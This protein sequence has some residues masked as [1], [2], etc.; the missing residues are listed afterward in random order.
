VP[1]AAAIAEL[2]PTLAPRARATVRLAIRAFELSPFPR[3]FSSLGPGRATRHIER[4]E[5]SR[6]GLRRDLALLLKT[7]TSMAFC[8]DER[9][10]AAVGAKP[11]CERSGEGERERAG[12][13]TAAAPLEPGALVAPEG[14]EECDVVVVGSGAGGAAAARVLAEAGLSVVVLEEG[15]YLSAREFSPDPWAALRTLYRDGG[16]TFCEGRPAIPVPLGRCVGGTTVINSGTCRRPNA[17]VFASWREDFG[18]DWATELDSEFQGLER[19][20]GVEPVTQAAAGRNGCLCMA[21][22]DAIEASNGPIT[23]NADGV[24][25]CA[26]CPTG[27]PIDCKQAMHVSELP[28]A[29]A[30]GC[31]VRAS[32]RVDRVL[33]EGSRAVGVSGRAGGERRYDV[34]ARAVVVAAGAVGTPDL[35]LRQRL[36]GASRHLGRHLHIQPAC[37][38]GARFD[39]PVRGWEGVMQSWFV[40]EWRDRGL[41]LEATAT[42]LPFGAH[43]MP[44]AGPA[45]EER[46]ERYG[47]LAVIGVHLADRSE[48]RVGLAGRRARMTYRLTRDDAELIRFGIAR[49]AEIHCAA[50]ARE[51]YPQLA[52]LQ[53][54]GPEDGVEAIERHAVRPRKLRL[55]AFHPMGT[56][57][58]GSSPRSSA[59]A[60]TGELHGLRGLYV[61]DASLL[62]TALGTNP[63]LTIMACAR[64]VARGLAE[65]L[66]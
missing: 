28:R 18:I 24:V 5:T 62:P 32:V 43:W 45:F 16:L 66:T 17:D 41:F 47:H 58:M 19:D 6:L 12:P 44:G 53:A 64:H 4:M 2:Y 15:P 23:R 22:A 30:A 10:L 40:D 60:P 35:L 20:L 34:R 39:D 59:T 56:A 65:Q 50:G 3:R 33:L 21:G 52:G 1:V 51:V 37:W 26:S 54:V 55:E 9:V 46:V 31:R 25:R 49:A 29:A 42:P 57:R 7:L 11:G 38:V 14:E 13:S 36:P 61:A 27:C 8:R 48:G 63:M